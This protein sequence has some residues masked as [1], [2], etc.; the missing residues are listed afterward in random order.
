LHHGSREDSHAQ[1]NPLKTRKKGRRFR[2]GPESKILGE[3]RHIGLIFVHRSTK[4]S[5][6]QNAAVQKNL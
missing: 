3:D 1:A 4:K 2:T 5:K 6:T